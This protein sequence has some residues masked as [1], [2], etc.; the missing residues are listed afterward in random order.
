[1]PLPSFPTLV[2]RLVKGTPLTHSEGDEN[3]DKIKAYSEMLAALFGVALNPDGTLN[4]D[5]VKTINILNRQVTAAKLAPVS[6]FPTASDTGTTNAI[7]IANV[8]PLTAYEDGQVFFV[9]I[10]NTNTGPATLNVDSIGQVTIRKRGV[11]D[12]DA[13][14]YEGG[15]IVAIGYFAGSFHL[16]SGVGGTNSSS[17][18]SAGFSG[19]QTYQSSDIAIPP[20]AAVAATGTLSA[21]ANFADGDTVTIDSGGN[22]RVYRFKNTMSAAYDVQRDGSTLAASLANLAAAIDASG[23]PGTEY[24]AGTLAHPTVST[25]VLGASSLKVVADTAGI[26]GNSIVTTETSSVASWGGGTLTGGITDT[27]HAFTHGLP[28]APTQF[29]VYLI[30]VVADLTFTPGQLVSVNNCTDASGIPSFVV[31]ADATNLVVSRYGTTIEPSG[32]GA[33]DETKWLL[34]ASA[35]IATNTSSVMFPAV[36]FLSRNPVGAWSNGEDLFVVNTGKTATSQINRIKLSSGNVT[37]LTNPSSGPNP[38]ICNGAP[39]LRADS[40]QAFVFTSNTGVYQLSMLEPSTTWQPEQLTAVASLYYFHKP[41]HII[42][43]SGITK[44]YVMPSTYG[45]PRF[46]NNINLIELTMSSGAAVDIGSAVDFTS[47]LILSADG[48]AGNVEFK[49]MNPSG[50][51]IVPHMI[52]YNKAKKRLYIITDESSLLHIFEINDTGFSDP[53]SILEWWTNGGRYGLLRYIKTIAVGGS[54]SAPSP[55]SYG[56]GYTI[57]I[58]LITGQERAIVFYRTGTSIAGEVVRVPWRE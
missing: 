58:D 45:A 18:L 23:T 54:G 5:V 4:D 33:I 37:R 12:L 44:V 41:V 21:S 50:G 20:V 42:D 15:S 57:D 39:F 9:K 6:V 56:D 16:I 2:K 19:F 43:S 46:I 1:M 36:Q 14:D 53:G 51:S 22:Q 3:L 35:R 49:A 7:K 38:A 17:S 28:Y 10:L 32:A 8:P 29:D 48:T 11:V 24:Y 34:R 55:T 13:G 25:S 27:F 26:G 31:T 30:N 52:Q 47:A 40:S